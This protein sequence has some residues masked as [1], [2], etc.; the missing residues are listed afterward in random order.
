LSVPAASNILTFS[1]SPFRTAS[2][3]S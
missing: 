3:N 1:T 2:F